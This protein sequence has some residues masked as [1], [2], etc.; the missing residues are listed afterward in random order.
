MSSTTKIFDRQRFIDVLKGICVLLVVITHYSWSEAERLKYLFPFWVD[1]AVPIFMIISGYVYAQ[2]FKRRNVV[3]IEEAYVLRDIVYRILRYTVPYVVIFVIAMFA[4]TISG[5]MKFD[6]VQIVFFFLRGSYGPGS[7]Y[8]PIIMQFIFVFPVIY[9]LITK[10]Q[11]KGL[12]ICG[13]VNF[14]YELLQQAYQ[15]GEECYRLLLFR[16][17]F[18]ISFGCYLAIGKSKISKKTYMIL[19]LVGIIFIIAYQYLGYEPV[20]ITEW[21]GTSFVA[22]LYI[23]PIAAVLLRKISVGN[24]VVEVVGKASYNI[25]LVQMIYY[26]N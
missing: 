24:R 16:Y 9:F 1:M 11:I 5:R 3:R 19:M 12:I 6:V 14:L 22:C 10:Y 20:I 13:F 4:V 26:L 17:I 21:T 8:Y 15:M 25:F 18:V 7:Y 23:L 2:S